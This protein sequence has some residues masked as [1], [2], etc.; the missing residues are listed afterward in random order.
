MGPF[1]GRA[2]RET[3]KGRNR[4]RNAHF[5][6][7]LQIS[8]D[9]RL[10]L[11]IKGFVSRRFA[12]K[13]ADFR[14]KPQKTHLLSPF[15]RAPTFFAFFSRNAFFGRGG[16]KSFRVERLDVSFSDPYLVHFSFSKET[17]HHAIAVMIILKQS[18]PQ[19]KDLGGRYD[20]T[21]ISRDAVF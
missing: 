19:S 13:T 12:Q 5:R 18:G 14:R 20:L 1:S 4:T 3:A 9:F 17:M 8:A 7:F 15:W 10:A 21:G 16:A 6:R 2:K 11:Q